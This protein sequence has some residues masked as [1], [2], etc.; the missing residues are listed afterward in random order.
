MGPRKLQASGVHGF[1]WYQ[2]RKG[3]DS[4]NIEAVVVVAEKVVVKKE[5]AFAGKKEKA[6]AAKKEKASVKRK[7]RLGLLRKKRIWQT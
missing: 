3:F 1:G 7:K 6:L 2:E 5:K 4:Q